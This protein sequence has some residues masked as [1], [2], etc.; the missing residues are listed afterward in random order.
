VSEHYVVF[1]TL[2][3]NLLMSKIICELNATRTA[4]MAMCVGFPELSFS[5]HGRQ[6]W[7]DGRTEDGV[8]SVMQPPKRRVIERER[9]ACDY[10]ANTSVV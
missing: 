9:Y 10:A 6:W 7:R 3:F 1:V 8:Q 5:T 2:T 4:V